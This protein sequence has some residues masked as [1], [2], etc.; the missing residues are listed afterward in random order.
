MESHT[1]EAILYRVSCYKMSMNKLVSIF[2]P[3]PPLLDDENLKEEFGKCMY[4][5]PLFDV[6]ST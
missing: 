1:K 2:S 5:L 4:L 3:P 6:L